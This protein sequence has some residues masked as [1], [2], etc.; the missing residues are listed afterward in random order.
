[1]HDLVCYNDVE[2]MLNRLR[3]EYWVIKGRQSV[4][5]VLKHYSTCKYLNPKPVLSAETVDLPNFH[6]NCNHA[7][8]NVGIDFCVPIYCKNIYGASE[9]F[10]RSYVLLFKYTVTRAVR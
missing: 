7:F 3:N 4:T 9:D 8:E 2:G 6:I 1:M 10:N 5:K